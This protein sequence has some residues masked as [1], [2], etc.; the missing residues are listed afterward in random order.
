MRN[1]W[2]HLEFSLMSGLKIA[3]KPLLL[4]RYTRNPP[5]ADRFEDGIFCVAK[6]NKQ[7]SPHETKF[8]K[9][10]IHCHCEIL[11]GKS[12]RLGRGGFCIAKMC[13]EP[14]GEA[15]S[16]KIQ[17]N[18]KNFVIL[19]VAKYLKIQNSVPK[20]SKTNPQKIHTFFA[21]NSCKSQIFSV[22][23]SLFSKFL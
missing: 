13:C 14:L 21:K 8:I 11:L 9:I 15:K 6:N 17:K 18:S 10:H 4:L 16:T 23:S 1:L 12:W 3:D 2:R 5:C 7:R 20:K 22:F 19:S